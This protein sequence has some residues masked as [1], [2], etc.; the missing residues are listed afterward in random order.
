MT[1]LV[2]LTGANGFVG[3]QVLKCL[4][5]M[6]CHVRIVLRPGKSEPDRHLSNAVTR[7]YTED[8]FAESADWWESA[9][10]GVHTVI[11][12]AWYVQ[13]GDY[14]HSVKNLECLSGSLW[15]ARGASKAGIKRFVGV[16]TCLEYDL[17]DPTAD[18]SVNSPLNPVTPYAGAKVA[19][20]NALSTWCKSQNIS[21]AWCRL[22]YLHGE[23]ED[24]RR[25]LPYVRARLAAGLAAELTQG[26]QIRDYLDVHDAGQM[27]VR[28]ALGAFQGPVNVCS[29]RPVTVR[30]LVESVVSE[31]A[32]PDLLAF[33]ARSDNLADPSRVVGVPTPG[34]MDGTGDFGKVEVIA[35]AAVNK[36][37]SKT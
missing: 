13:S 35:L 31:F 34:L 14:L 2:L 11:H 15:L 1:R 18:L 10:A 28:A 5:M 9:C 27:L 6:G 26:H 16:G 36:F 25:L 4:L 22:F 33:G 24:P 30:Q 20:F 21:F 17:S 3:R 37:T 7:I 8:L 23:G 32:R 19:A 29:G 12:V